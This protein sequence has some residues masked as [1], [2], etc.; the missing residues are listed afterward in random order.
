MA[1]ALIIGRDTQD[2]SRFPDLLDRIPKLLESLQP[3][4][5]VRIY[6]DL[7]DYQ[8]IDF[9]LVWRHPFGI[10]KQLSNLKC[11]ASLA[12]ALIIYLLTRICRKL[13][14][15]FVL[16]IPQCLPKLLNMWSLRCYIGLNVLITGK[17]SAAKVLGQSYA[18]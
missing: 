5:D 7:G 9:A 1:I 2:K 3:G 10:F 14:P 15:L 16:S 12:L 6:P 11:I 13:F 4:L 18:I 8:D 17:M